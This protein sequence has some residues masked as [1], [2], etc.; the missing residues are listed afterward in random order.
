MVLC[1]LVLQVLESVVISLDDPV[2]L[3]EG[4]NVAMLNRFV[5]LHSLKIIVLL[6]RTTLTAGSVEERSR[7][8]TRLGG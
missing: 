5:A 3:I 2:S 8:G 4:C 1:D 6:L 7:G